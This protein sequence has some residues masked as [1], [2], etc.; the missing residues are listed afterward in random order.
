M[1][2][3]NSTSMVVSS[4]DE[5]AWLLNMRGR[6]I[7]FGAVFFSY[8]IITMDSCKLFTNL[9][10]LEQTYNGTDSFKSYLLGEDNF[11]FYEYDLFLTYLNSHIQEEFVN[12]YKD[13]STCKKVQIKSTIN[14]SI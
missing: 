11:E 13:K 12:K 7:P 10:R 3:S 14:F 2:T 8:C 4:M 1:E 5:I 6:D 9:S